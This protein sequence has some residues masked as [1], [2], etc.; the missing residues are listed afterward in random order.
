MELSLSITYFLNQINN[1]NDR[2][3]FIKYYNNFQN[4]LDH[5]KKYIQIKKQLLDNIREFINMLTM[6]LEDVHYLRYLSNTLTN[7]SL[8]N[9]TIYDINVQINNEISLYKNMYK[10]INGSVN[11]TELDARNYKELFKKNLFYLIKK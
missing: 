4:H 10:E 3:F 6:Q 2:D 5:A 11:I 9:I 1:L 8:Q 7:K